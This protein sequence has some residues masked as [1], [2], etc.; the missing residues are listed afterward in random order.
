[1]TK[2]V[3]I[4]QSFQSCPWL[5]S[6]R[7]PMYSW[8]WPQTER[9]T[10]YLSNQKI[11]W[12]LWKTLIAKPL[13]YSIHW[14]FSVDFNAVKFLPWTPPS[15]YKAFASMN[16]VSCALTTGLCAWEMRKLSS[17]G[18]SKGGQASPPRELSLEGLVCLPQPY[19]VLVIVREKLLVPALQV[20]NGWIQG[21]L[22]THPLPSEESSSGWSSLS[23]CTF[24]SMSASLIICLRYTQAF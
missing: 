7:A 24:R 11:I 20:M 21:T 9:K 6:V 15:V 1:M 17:D 18:A 10:N 2:N 12:M 8:L 4:F 16:W 19:T 23:P 13:L 22:K 3:D 5:C 14:E